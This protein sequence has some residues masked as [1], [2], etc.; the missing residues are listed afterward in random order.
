[1]VA[2]VHDDVTMMKQRC[3]SNIDYDG[4]DGNGG[5]SGNDGNGDGN[6][7]DAM[8]AADGDDVNDDNSGVSRTA[9]GRR[10]LD[11][12]NGTTTM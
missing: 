12:D 5:D 6:G 2:K 3:R 8:A 1:L 7:D 4:N 9:I 11:D 10:Q